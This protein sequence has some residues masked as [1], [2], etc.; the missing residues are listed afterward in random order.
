M[1]LM[2]IHLY[3]LCLVSLSLHH[4]LCRAT[5]VS[6]WG[7]PSCDCDKLL[8]KKTQC[9]T[10]AEGNLMHMMWAQ[11]SCVGRQRRTPAIQPT[12]FFHRDPWSTIMKAVKDCNRSCL[13]SPK[14][15]DGWVLKPYASMN[16][17]WEAQ[18]IHTVAHRHDSFNPM[19]CVRCSRL[20]KFW[21]ESCM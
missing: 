11:V 1:K 5:Q 17:N 10:W 19:K 18:H 7:I 2:S 3:A 6:S 21:L 9:S 15:V 16:G 13:T 20:W 14:D 8:K 4:L 12:V